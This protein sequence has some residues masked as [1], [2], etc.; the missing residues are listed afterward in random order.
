MRPEDRDVAYV[1]DMLD[2]ARAAVSFTEGSSF[3]AFRCDAR[4]MRAVERELEIIGEAARRISREFREAAPQIPWRELVGLRNI[5]S[6]EYDRLDS[7]RIFAISTRFL[8]ELT[9]LLEQLA[10]APPKDV[11]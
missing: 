6:H 4:T 2:A 9:V 1:W 5:I 3:E 11:D 8:V 7:Q 10:P